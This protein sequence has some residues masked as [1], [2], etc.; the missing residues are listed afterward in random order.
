M[1]TP[2]PRSWIL[3]VALALAAGGVGADPGDARAES[4][5]SAAAQGRSG[6]DVVG[7]A[8][9]GQATVAAAPGESPGSG[10]ERHQAKKREMVRRMLMLMVAYR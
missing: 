9:P 7:R 4:P 8:A 10:V 3:A 2:K 6:W 1:T 5:A